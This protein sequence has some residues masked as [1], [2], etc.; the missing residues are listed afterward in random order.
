MAIKITSAS[1]GMKKVKLAVGGGRSGQAERAARLEAFAPLLFAAQGHHAG[2]DITAQG[3]ALMD[4]TLFE[5][6]LK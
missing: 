6:L 3:F 1:E 4:S 5:V 2:H